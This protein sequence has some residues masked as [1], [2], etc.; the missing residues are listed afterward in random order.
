MCH[1]SSQ[2]LPRRSILAGL[3]SLLT[4]GVV[5]ASLYPV[6]RFLGFHLPVKPVKV[7]IYKNLLPNGFLIQKDFIL[8]NDPEKPWA[9]SRTCTHLGCHLNLNENAKLLI[10]PCH[11]SKFDYQG[12]RVDGPAKKNLPVYQVEKLAGIE[13]SGF[14]VT[15]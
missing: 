7:T 15:M 14:I 2:N 1:N 12:I 6:F 9:V 11:Q 4:V 5:G 8:F 10:C 3:G 13:G